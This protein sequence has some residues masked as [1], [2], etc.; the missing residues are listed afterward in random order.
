MVNPG[1]LVENGIDQ[2]LGALTTL[3]GHLAHLG[4]IRIC[5]CVTAAAMFGGWEGWSPSAEGGMAQAVLHQ[6]CDPVLEVLAH[7]YGRSFG[8]VHAVGRGDAAGAPGVKNL[9]DCLVRKGWTVR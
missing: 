4:S 1:V 2:D 6:A 9:L 8:E 7:H 3:V 5:G